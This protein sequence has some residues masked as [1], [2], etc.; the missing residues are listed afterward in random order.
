MENLNYYFNI[1]EIQP[2]TSLSKIKAA[3]RD[4]AT[5]WHPDRYTHNLRLQ[6]KAEE[7]LKLIN[8]AYEVLNS[9][10]RPVP[11]R[12]SSI[13]LKDLKQANNRSINLVSLKTGINYSQ[14]EELLISRKWL[15]ADQ[16]TALLMLSA[17]N[18]QAD[19][20]LRPTKDINSFPCQ[21][22]LIINQ[23]WEK[24]SNGKF[25]FMAQSCVWEACQLRRYSIQDFRSPNEEIKKDWCRFGEKVGWRKNQLWSEKSEI[26][27]SLNAPQ[28]SLP[29][30]FIHWD[31]SAQMIGGFIPSK[32][33]WDFARW[34]SSG[35]GTEGNSVLASGQFWLAY[36]LSRFREC[37]IN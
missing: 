7:K 5:V 19:G 27:F 28:G 31:Y 6:R 11:K 16:E 17:C 35:L 10:L 12:S 30:I 37:S 13:I 4:L 9:A 14:L 21:D 25:G 33:A 36:L 2:T 29:I 26:E 24:Y 22:L 3:Y 8:E 23:L 32:T 15:Q 1:L 20:W 34:L 18:R